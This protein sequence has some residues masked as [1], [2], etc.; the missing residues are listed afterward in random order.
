MAGNVRPNGLTGA[1]LLL[2]WV[3]VILLA[4]AFVR[5]DI[6]GEDDITGLSVNIAAATA[7]QRDAAGVAFNEWL[8]QS[9]IRDGDAGDGSRKNRNRKRDGK[10]ERDGKRGG[11]RDG[12]RGG[13]RGGKRRDDTW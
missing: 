5:V 8:S 12:K 11:K 9:L 13:K 2:F 7:S 1:C 6:R 4:L 10:R 3:C